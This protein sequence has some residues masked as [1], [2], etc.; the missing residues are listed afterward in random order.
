[1]LLRTCSTSWRQRAEQGAGAPAG[2][3]AVV[4]L[5]GVLCWSSC[6]GC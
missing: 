6:W 1:M 5:L 3:W 2:G 4:W